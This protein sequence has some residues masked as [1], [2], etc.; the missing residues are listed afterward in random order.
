MVE[1][2][3]AVIKFAQPVSPGTALRVELSSVRTLS[4]LGRVWLM[5]VTVRGTESAK[6]LSVGM[7][8]IHTY[9]N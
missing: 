4:M 7:A 1:D 8:R 3:T 6:D 2:R 5:P 9:N